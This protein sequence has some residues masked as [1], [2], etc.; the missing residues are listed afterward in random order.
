MVPDP[1]LGRLSPVASPASELSAW[2]ETSN[3]T[4]VWRWR[5]PSLQKYSC[6]SVTHKTPPCIDLVYAGGVCPLQ[7]PGRL[8]TATWHF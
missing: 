7:S 1:G 3:F 6:H 4:V 5:N 8:S 2:V